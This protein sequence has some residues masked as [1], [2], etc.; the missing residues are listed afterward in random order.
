MACFSCSQGKSLNAI[1]ILQMYKEAS[2][3]S[4][5]MYWFYKDASDN[6]IKLMTDADF[7]KYKSA[8]KKLFQQGQIE[9]ARIDEFR[10]SEN[11]PIL[12]DSR[13]K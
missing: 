1:N 10:I 9:F 4:G 2:E 13:D 7:K 5:T 3:K 12:E 11:H 8:N 6:E